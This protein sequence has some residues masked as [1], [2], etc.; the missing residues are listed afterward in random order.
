M[1]VSFAGIRWY[2]IQEFAGI[3]YRN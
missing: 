2:N 1:L 3:V